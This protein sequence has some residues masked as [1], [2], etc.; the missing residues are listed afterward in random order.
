MLRAVLGFELVY[1][2]SSAGGPQLLDPI[3]S[4]FL[5]LGAGYGGVRFALDMVKWL[6]KPP[7]PPPRSEG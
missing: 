3:I 4:L 1:Y 6:R 7:P 5:L 2:G